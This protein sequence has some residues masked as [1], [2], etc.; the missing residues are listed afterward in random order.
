[1]RLPLVAVLASVMLSGCATPHFYQNDVIEA[2]A[3]SRAVTA[4]KLDA[5]NGV[6]TIYK[7]N[8]ANYAL[9]PGAYQTGNMLLDV[10]SATIL[11][12]KEAE[13]L[14]ETCRRIVEAY[15]KASGDDLKVIE[16]HL[17]E[18]AVQAQTVVSAFAYQG[19]ASATTQT[20]L[21]QAV[22]LRLQYTYQP[23]A[24]FGSGEKIHY[25]F[26]GTTA[27]LKI[28]Q[29]RALLEDLQK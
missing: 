22:A 5:T 24:L 9:V 27:D 7:V 6:I 3:V 28:E 8:G 29:V 17:V 1:M 12:E 16:Y 13:A 10:D 2:S 20:G 19:L 11:G 23:G 25:S 21:Y 14:R 26:G 15:G 4:R 18:K